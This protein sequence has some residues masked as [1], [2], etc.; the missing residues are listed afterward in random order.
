MQIFIKKTITLEVESSDSIENVM[1]MIQDKEGI[2]PDQQ[3]L[4][5]ASNQ[6]EKR[7]TLSNYNIHN[8]ST[9]HLVLRP[10][11]D[12]QIF[13]KELNG[14]MTKFKVKTSDSIE[15]LRAKI[16][17]KLGI[18]PDKHRLIFAGRQLE[19]GRTLS[20]YKIHDGSRLHLV[21]RIRG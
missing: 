2:P 13:I 3:L 14:K 16:H 17:D 6:L 20:S 19:N 1:A 7:R 5:F 12:I 18:I 11:D 10:R 8:G 21:M 9:L 15:N 4:I